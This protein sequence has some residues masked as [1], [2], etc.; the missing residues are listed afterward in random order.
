MLVHKKHIIIVHEQAIFCFKKQEN[1]IMK[2]ISPCASDILKYLFKNKYKNQRELSR[3]IGHSLGLVN[4]S[5]KELNQLGL[6]DNSCC[7]TDDA[8]ELIKSIKP[9]RAIILAAGGGTRMVPINTISPKALIEVHKETLIERIIRHLHEVNIYE[10]YVVIGFMKEQLEFLIDEYG[11]NLIVNTEYS[12]RE[13]LHSLFLAKEHLGNAYI[14]PCDIWSRENPFNENEFYSWYMVSDEKSGSS[15]IRL[16][17]KMDLVVTK[18]KNGNKK[19]GL[20]YLT[21]EDGIRLKDRLE[22][23]AEDINHYNLFWEDALKDANNSRYIIR[24]REVSDDSV[25]GI[26]TYEDLREI[27]SDSKNLDEKSIEIIKDVFGAKDKDIKNISVLKKGMTNR[28]FVF[29]CKGEKYIMRI[30]G[31]G[32]EKLIN[33]DNEASVYEAIRD[34]NLCENPIYLD[35]NSGYKITRYLERTRNCNPFDDRDVSLCMKKLKE[36]HNQKLRVKHEFNIYKEIDLYESLLSGKGSS[37]RDYKKT[38]EKILS[39][40][41]FIDSMV[42]EKCL[43]HIDAVPDNFLIYEENGEKRV[44]LIDWEYA[45]MQ[46]PHID[47]AMFAIYSLYD[48]SRIDW[49]INLYFEN[50]EDIL[51]RAKIYAYISQCGLLWSNWAEYKSSLGVEFGEYSL[52]QY[53]YAKEYY[54]Y[55]EEILR[56]KQII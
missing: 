29:S 13:N 36:F 54:R 9:H 23:M 56:R 20:A 32:T 39:L 46:D 15:E 27:D 28:S 24:G 44:Q 11:V 16:N 38:K 30:P 12:T 8:Y 49:L 4:R 37:F 55:A 51:I 52:S 50:N 25:I 14:V 45:G 1:L 41:P 5:I 6:I 42:N 22:K 18:E 3:N 35:K 7:L 17:R 43:T 47:I 21:K 40:K 19:K 48:K 53:R 26:N 2:H 34:K 33:R 31:E 10:I